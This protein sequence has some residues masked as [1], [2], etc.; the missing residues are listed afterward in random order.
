VA[1]KALSN[2]AA[3]VHHKVDTPET[4][5]LKSRDHGFSIEKLVIRILETT[6]DLLTVSTRT[7][8][9]TTTSDGDETAKPDVANVH[10]HH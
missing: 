1:A 10:A 9:V 4:G 2:S 3:A 8:V 6:T 7:G 5:T